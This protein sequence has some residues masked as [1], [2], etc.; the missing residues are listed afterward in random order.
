MTPA[1]NPIRH[2]YLDVM[3]GVAVGFAMGVG[4]TVFAFVV[5]R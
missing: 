5:S 1:L 3:V 4:L 2:D